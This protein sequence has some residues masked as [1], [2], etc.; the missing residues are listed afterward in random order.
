[1]VGS[2][3]NIEVD[4]GEAED[5]VHQAERDLRWFRYFAILT[6][7]E[8]QHFHPK[9][10]CQ[11]H[12]GPKDKVLLS[13]SS[14]CSHETTSCQLLKMEARHHQKSKS[15]SSAELARLIIAVTSAEDEDHPQLVMSGQ[16]QESQESYYSSL[17]KTTQWVRDRKVR[18][19]F[20]MVRAEPNT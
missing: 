10:H 17:N 8:N 12:R 16:L 9:K 20:A 6:Q 7:I 1:M 13:E 15:F 11:G 19:C 4:P 18:K 2:V 5:C 3:F 14:K